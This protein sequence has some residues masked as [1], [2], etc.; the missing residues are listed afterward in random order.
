[1]NSEWL[2]T[3]QTKFTAY[4]TIYILIVVAV[5]GLVNWLAQRHN[6]SVDTTANKRFS[7][8]DQ[9]KKVIGGLKQDVK[10]TYFDKTSS[11]GQAKDLLDRYDT[12]STKLS[13]D[14]VDPDKKPQIAK[15]VGVKSYGT[16]MVD[17]GPKHQEAKA[18]TEEEITGAIIRTLKGGD[19]TVCVVSGSGEHKMDDTGRSGYSG[20]KEQIEKNNYKT[21]E[22][23]LL[24]KPEVPKDCTITLVAG[25][26]FDYVPPVVDALKKYQEGGG[27]L[28]L[29]LDPPVKLG[30]EDVTE[31]AALAKVVEGW[32]V[33]LNN[34]LVLDT[35]GIGQVFGFSEV[36]PLVT[37]YENQPIVREMKG[38]ATAFPLARSLEATGSA[39]K[40]FSTSD[41]SF[42]TTKLSGGEI[43]ID[44]AKDKHGPF[45]L[46]AAGS[47]KV[48]AS[49]A[50][51]VVVGSSGWVANN[52]VSFNGN[53]DLFLNMLNWLSADEDLISIRP[54]DPEDR[55][56]TMNK[57]QML[58]VFYSS[59]ILLPLFSILAGFSV[60]W[61]RR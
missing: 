49:Q 50:R 14:Y 32:G 23:S 4:V 21:R 33:K 61:K 7:L 11:F 8:S 41:N 44:P 48:G 1:M 16:I 5:L 27:R 39:E 13:V 56:I 46:G 42:A 2:K 58:M 31:N 28:L 55:R 29:F 19:R 12:L 20:I 54:K 35:S 36:V 15:Q 3:R 25:P 26:R 24:D 45:L 30:K 17:S 53:K 6:K 57:R 60:W 51:F 38:V 9:T 52:I 43:R 40:L 22:I 37:S 59:V 18:V 34:D 10:I 47:V